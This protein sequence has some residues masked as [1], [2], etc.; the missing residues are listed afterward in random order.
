MGKRLLFGMF[1]AEAIS[2]KYI[3]SKLLASNS[4]ISRTRFVA[5]W[6]LEFELL[7]IKIFHPFLIVFYTNKY[8]IF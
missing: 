2:E 7:F 3:P 8:T 5:L 4:K 1:S 6:L